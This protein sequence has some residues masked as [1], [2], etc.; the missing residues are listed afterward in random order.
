MTWASLIRWFL[1]KKVA[2]FLEN[3]PL[4]GMEPQLGTLPYLAQYCLL[5]QIWLI[6]L[7]CVV[8]DGESVII[9]FI[10]GRSSWMNGQFELAPIKLMA[11]IDWTLVVVGQRRH[12]AVHCRLEQCANENIWRQYWILPLNRNLPATSK[13]CLLWMLHWVAD[14]PNRYNNPAI[15]PEFH[16]CISF[17]Q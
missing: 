6:R 14:K 9:V 3:D 5:I 10:A 17:G 11:A 1:P 13:S 4:W 16:K 12:C 2:F 15:S 8:R 7:W